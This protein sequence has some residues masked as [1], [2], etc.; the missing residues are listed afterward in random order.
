MISTVLRSPRRGLLSS[1]QA[2][3]TAMIA[4]T[5][6]IRSNFAMGFQTLQ[7]NGCR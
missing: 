5:Q 2:I 1:A 6:D 3:G 4:M 7:Q